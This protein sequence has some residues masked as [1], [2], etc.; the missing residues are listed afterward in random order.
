[1]T[2]SPTSLPVPLSHGNGGGTFGTS[3]YARAARRTHRIYDVIASVTDSAMLGVGYTW[4][5]CR[6]FSLIPS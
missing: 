2:L 4:F 6:Q 5:S 3:L 1:M